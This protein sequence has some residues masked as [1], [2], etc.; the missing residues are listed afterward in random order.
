MWKPKVG[1]LTIPTKIIKIKT[2]KL[3]LKLKW[4]KNIKLKLKLKIYKRNIKPKIRL[5]F[6]R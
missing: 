2:S 5:K 1:I 3:K 6:K 4:F